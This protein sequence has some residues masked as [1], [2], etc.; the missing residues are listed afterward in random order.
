MYLFID[1]E[2]RIGT[3][4]RPTT[5]V[6]VSPR[7]SGTWQYLQLLTEEQDK[8][9][10]DGG[11]WI[12]QLLPLGSE[13]GRRDVIALMR[14]QTSTDTN[15]NYDEIS[16]CFLL[17]QYESQWYTTRSQY[18][19]I[20][21][22][23]WELDNETLSRDSQVWTNYLNQGDHDLHGNTFVKSCLDLDVIS[24]DWNVA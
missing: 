2:L 17:V 10:D 16:Q 5:S 14:K 20:G 24:F 4:R 7:V 23:A 18:F 11:A 9:D 22:P 6:H 12:H 15:K 1:V 13:V 8:R 3:G 19:A 21:K